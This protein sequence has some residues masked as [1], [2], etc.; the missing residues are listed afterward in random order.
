MDNKKYS[1]T[2]AD[3]TVISDLRLNGNN[4]ISETPLTPELFDGNCSTV[5][6]RKPTPT[7]S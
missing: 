5:R 1:I 6:Q 3:G 7:W 2:L 4:Y